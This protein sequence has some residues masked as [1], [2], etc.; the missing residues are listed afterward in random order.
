MYIPV[1][2]KAWTTTD[3]RNSVNKFQMHEMK[4]KKIQIQKGMYIMI[5]FLWHFEKG[6][7]IG[8]ENKSVL[9]KAYRFREWVFTTKRP[10]GTFCG[11]LSIL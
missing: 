2:I 3:T 1:Y 10:R 11:D 8:I 7:T 9:A 6:K 5:L 4:K